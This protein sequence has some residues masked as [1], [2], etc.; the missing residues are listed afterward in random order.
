MREADLTGH[1]ARPDSVSLSE[2]TLNEVDCALKC[3]G[4]Q[5][6]CKSPDAVCIYIMLLNYY[7]GH[8]DFSYAC[9]AHWLF[10]GFF[11]YVTCCKVSHDTCGRENGLLWHILLGF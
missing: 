2:L 7:S 6:C 4:V 1:K 10:K 9:L 11:A 3:E 5:T 8:A